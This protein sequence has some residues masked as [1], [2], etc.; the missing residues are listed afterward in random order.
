MMGQGREG[1]VYHLRPDFWGRMLKNVG[2][3]FVVYHPTQHFGHFLGILPH[4]VWLWFAVVEGD[5]VW[6]VGR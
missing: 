6:F 4:R 1:L 2:F 5:E 3:D